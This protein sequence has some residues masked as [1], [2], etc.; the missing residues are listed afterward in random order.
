VVRREEE[1]Y[2]GGYGR[3]VE[4]ARGQPVSGRR[5]LDRD[6]VYEA[7]ESYAGGQLAGLTVDRD[8][9]GRPEYREQFGPQGSR[10]FWDYDDDG[11]PDSR[12][13]ESPEGLLREFSSR[14]DGV[15]DAAAIFRGDRLV[16]FR[17]GGRVLSVGPSSSAGVF[18]VGRPAGRP[19]RFLG[20]P[21]GIHRLEDGSFFV[22]S[23]AGRRY[24][25]QL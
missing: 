17:R 6:G 5:D 20:L 24:V 15:F 12:E 23:Y 2:D 9:D 3:I 13:T 18:W 14:W 16:E 21:D 1:P 10:R 4:Y 22:F 19:E 11:R 7:R 8:G 25:E